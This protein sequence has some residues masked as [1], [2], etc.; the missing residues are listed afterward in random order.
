[1]LA[2]TEREAIQTIIV[3]PQQIQ[4]GWDYVP[5]QALLFTTTGLIHLLAS[6]WQNQEPQLTFGLDMAEKRRLLDQRVALE[7][8]CQ[9]A[10]IFINFCFT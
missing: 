3:F 2:L 5:K 10:R 9:V 1:V 6:I 8:K 7:T 4:R